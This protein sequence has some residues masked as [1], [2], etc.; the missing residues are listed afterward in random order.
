[1]NLIAQSILNALLNYIDKPDRDVLTEQLMN[2][3]QLPYFECILAR[4]TDLNHLFDKIFEVTH[5]EPL[6]STFSRKERC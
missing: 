6:T 3:S 2:I 1:M 5:I 4:E